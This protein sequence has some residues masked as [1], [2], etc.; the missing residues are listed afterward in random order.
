MTTA[1]VK[2]TPYL[3]TK[4]APYYVETVVVEKRE[5]AHEVAEAQV[6]SKCGLERFS[7]VYH[8]E[9]L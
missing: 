7:P 8:T 3:G 5:Q 2:V 4:A 6:K 1:R 9:I